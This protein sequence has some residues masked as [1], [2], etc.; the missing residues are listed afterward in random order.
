MSAADSSEVA[1]DTDSAAALAGSAAPVGSAA[2]DIEALD[3][4][5]RSVL[6]VDRTGL[7]RWLGRDKQKEQR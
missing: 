2:L 7:E 4:E 5:A 1:L 6:A 3:I